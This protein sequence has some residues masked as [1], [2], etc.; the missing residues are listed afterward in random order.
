MRVLETKGT[1]FSAME[2]GRFPHGF[3]QRDQLGG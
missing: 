1:A 2:C 3:E